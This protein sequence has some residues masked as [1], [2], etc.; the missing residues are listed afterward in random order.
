[1]SA[2]ELA[3][4][5][6]QLAAFEFGHAQATP[7][8]GRADQRSVHQFEYG[9]FAEGMRDDLG[10]PSLLTEQPL[11]HV[12]SADR[13]PMREWEAQMGNARFKVVL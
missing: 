7:A 4:D 1:M 9:A 12:G 5:R 3:A 10:A 13:P 8:F 6:G 2:I 11:E